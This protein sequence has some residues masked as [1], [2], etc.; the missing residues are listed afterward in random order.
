MLFMKTQD[1]LGE[2][3]IDKEKLTKSAINKKV[4]LNFLSDLGLN[5][6]SEIMDSNNNNDDDDDNDIFGQRVLE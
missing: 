1:I 4:N 3:T 6:D 5:A 2:V